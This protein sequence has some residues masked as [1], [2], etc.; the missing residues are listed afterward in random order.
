VGHG[1]FGSVFK[2]NVRGCGTYAIKKLH[3][4]SEMQS[5]MEGTLFFEPL[6]QESFMLELQSLVKSVSMQFCCVII[7][8]H[9]Y[10]ISFPHN[11]SYG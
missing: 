9:K 6:H 8:I 5:E 11:H 7:R 3:N 2:A 4:R 10:Y 1:A